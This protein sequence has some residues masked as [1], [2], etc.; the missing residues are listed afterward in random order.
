MKAAVLGAG[1]I[2]QMHIEALRRIPQAEVVAVADADAE[3]GKAV[4]EGWGVPMFSTDYRR[5]IKESGADVVHVCT[6]TAL[7]FEM[8]R[9]AILA[10]KHL[11]CEKPLALTAAQGDELVLLARKADVLCA[12]NYNY[13]H[14]VMVEEMKERMRQ[15]ENGRPL[16]VTGHYLQDWLLYDTDFDWRLRPEI[17]GRS[18]AVADIGSHLF[19]LAQ[20]VLG[21]TIV[22]VYAK[23]FIAHPVRRRYEKTA[24]A[25]GEGRGALLEELQVANED[26]AFVLARFDN[27]LCA[28]FTLSQVAAGQK[29]ALSLTVDTSLHSLSWHQ[30][31]SDLLHVGVRNHGNFTVYRGSE[32]L[33]EAAKK[34]ATTPV[35]H[36]EGWSEAMKNAVACFYDAVAGSD[37]EAHQRYASIEHG[38]LTLHIVEACLESDKQNRWTN[39]NL[40][41]WKGR[42]TP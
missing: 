14:N 32:T 38:A 4:A 21:S 25:F 2:G 31:E 42:N 33:S 34:R 26:A 19:D 6:P 41:T 5:V 3:H 24:G 27:G 35:G 10:G 13:R 11:Y 37:P 23:L 15:E 18:R 7:H 8:S 40:S 16:L 22:S 20:Y 36:T 30:E 17:G 28:S 39:V 29:N 12:V 9:H 1:F